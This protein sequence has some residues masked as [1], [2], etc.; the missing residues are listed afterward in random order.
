MIVWQ[1][2]LKI[3]SWLMLSQ[4]RPVIREFLATPLWAEPNR[5]PTFQKG[6]GRK[7][8][9]DS[10]RNVHSGSAVLINITDHVKIWQFLDKRVIL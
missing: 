9:R 6:W 4:L 5:R 7:R 1:F 8:D 2:L 10:Q 3:L